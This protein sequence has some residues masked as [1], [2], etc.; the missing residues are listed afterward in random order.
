MSFFFT[1]M[2]GVLAW[3]LLVRATET[4]RAFGFQKAPGII[5]WVLVCCFVFA[6]VFVRCL[7]SIGITVNLWFLFFFSRQA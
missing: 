7:V 6:F 2:A 1:R 5:D 3:Y 4:F